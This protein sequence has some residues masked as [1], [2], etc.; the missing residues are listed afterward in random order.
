MQISQIPTKIPLPFAASGTRNVIP[1]ASQ[2]GI[3][4]GAAS[5]TDGFPPQND[6]DVSAGG[7]PPVRADFNGIFNLIS[8]LNQW[9][10]AG[11]P[12][13]YDA[14]FAAEI[15]GYPKGA[16]LASSVTPGLIWYSTVDNN[17]TNPDAG[18]AGWTTGTIGASSIGT[19]GYQK[20]ASGLIVQ[21][22]N[23]VAPTGNNDVFAF[24]TAFP[25]ACTSVVV[26]EGNPVGWVV[27]TTTANTTY[28]LE[29]TLYG[30]R[31]ISATQFQLFATRWIQSSASWAFGG[32]CGFWYIATGY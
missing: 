13:A 10:C 5:L 14:A 22:G 1:T 23:A 32:P 31:P 6:L 16:A 12:I 11:G 8:A 9:Y 21:Y 26:G 3:T 17:A 7:S 25:N 20:L 27:Y 24:P 15:G 30:A 2:I 19:S 18:G 29:P 28:I 4:L